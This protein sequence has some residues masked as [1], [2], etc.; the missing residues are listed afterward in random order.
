MKDNLITFINSLVVLTTRSFSIKGIL[1]Y[2][3]GCIYHYVTME[4][5][6]IKYLIVTMAQK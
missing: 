6:Y 3:V 4:T 2:S 5:L 1:L